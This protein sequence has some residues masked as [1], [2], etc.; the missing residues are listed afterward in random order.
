MYLIS[1]KG[2]WTLCITKPERA[3]V[4]ILPGPFELVIKLIRPFFFNGFEGFVAPMQS[5]DP[6]EAREAGI[7]RIADSECDKAKVRKHLQEITEGAAFKGS[8][9]SGK[10]LTF[11]VEQAIQGNFDSLKERVIGVELFGRDP[12]YDTG[13]DAVVRVTASD[14]RRRLLQHYGRYGSTAAFRISLPLGS[15]IPEISRSGDSE[16]AHGNVGET[17]PD[18]MPSSSQRATD[19]PLV[20]ETIPPATSVHS[21]S[22]RMARKRRWGL[23]SAIIAAS[24]LVVGGGFWIFSATQIK[25]VALVAPWSA[26]LRSTHG[27]HLITSDPNIAEI[28][29]YTGGQLSVSD[30]ANHN[31]IPEHNTLSPEVL[32]FCRVVLRGDKAAAIDTE[33]AVNIAQLLAPK[34]KK[35]DVRAARGIQVSDLKSDDDFVFFGSPRTNP[36]SALFS[37]QLDFRIVYD[38]KSGREFILN[39]HPKANE[40]QTY[41]PTAPGWATGQSY[42]IVAFVQNPDQIGQAL[43]LAGANGEGTQAAGKLVTDL[44]RLSRTLQLCGVPRFSAQPP[45]FEILLRLNTLAGSPNNVEIVACHLLQN[46]QALK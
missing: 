6:I 9:R 25:P 43:L 2:E 23:A 16:L 44:P 11:I 1:R 32:R 28:Q 12:S 22:E 33:I 36:W 41:V 27:L 21:E 35:L 45:H 5:M 37:E 46:A 10:F 30:Y 4:S 19:M 7:A 39:A 42:A 8:H 3:R 38:P 29:G 15:Y 13:D 26:F 17:T 14:V 31:Y 24:L 18:S 40:A 34:G 20:A